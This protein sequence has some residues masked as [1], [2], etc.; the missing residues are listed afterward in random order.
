MQR[1]AL[2]NLFDSL[3]SRWN[4]LLSKVDHEQVY[5]IETPNISHEKHTHTHPKLQAFAGLASRPTL[6]HFMSFLF[7]WIPMLPNGPL[8]CWDAALKSSKI[9]E[10]W[11][12]VVPSSMPV[13][14]FLVEFFCDVPWSSGDVLFKKKGKQ[15]DTKGIWRNACQCLSICYSEDWWWLKTLWIGWHRM[16]L[17]KFERCTAPFEREARPQRQ[18]KGSTIWGQ[19]RPSAYVFTCM[20]K[21]WV[22]S[23]VMD[24][25]FW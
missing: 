6:S 20:S 21:R 13:G 7:L 17:P 10:V 4:A 3:W 12:T 5:D 8:M 11:S 24:G 18:Q 25:K 16:A 9:A 19:D 1:I 14:R 15:K 22:S 2:D 23:A